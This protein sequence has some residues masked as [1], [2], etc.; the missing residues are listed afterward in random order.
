[1]IHQM[2]NGNLDILLPIRR[3]KGVPNKTID[4]E[5]KDTFK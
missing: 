4:S 3:L 5:V 1:M 2:M